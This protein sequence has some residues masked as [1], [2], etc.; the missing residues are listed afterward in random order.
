MATQLCP[1]SAQGGAG[2]LYPRLPAGVLGL[3][4]YFIALSSHIT[5]F[6]LV[7]PGPSRPEPVTLP[8]AN[9]TPVAPI[10]PCYDLG[11]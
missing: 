1:F 7:L 3:V 5:T 4:F 9:S 2:L 6:D 8:V 11:M 10:V